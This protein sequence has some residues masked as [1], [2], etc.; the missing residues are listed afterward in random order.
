[1]EPGNNGMRSGGVR[2]DATVVRRAPLAFSGC[3]GQCASTHSFYAAERPRKERAVRRALLFPFEE[4]ADGPQE[5]G[6]VWA[7]YPSRKSESMCL[8][9]SAHDD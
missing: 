4:R 6:P 7:Q 5:V 2:S 8:D 3:M 9:R 1:M